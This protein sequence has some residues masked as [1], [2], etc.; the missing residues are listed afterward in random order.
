MMG[1]YKKYKYGHSKKYKRGKS[2]SSL[3]GKSLDSAEELFAEG[4]EVVP[5]HMLR[6]TATS[7][8]KLM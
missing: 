6:F 5:A 4:W 1:D 2:R 8:N 3:C 7:S